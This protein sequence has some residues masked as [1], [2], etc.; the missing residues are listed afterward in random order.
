MFGTKMSGG[1]SGPEAGRSAVQTVRACGPD[2]PR[3]RKTDLG[4][5]F[6]AMFVSENLGISSKISL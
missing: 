6:L 5:E 3:K 4:S 1:Q 2:G